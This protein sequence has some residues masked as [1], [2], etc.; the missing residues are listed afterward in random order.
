MQQPE[1]DIY[2]LEVERLTKKPEK[3][4][5]AWLNKSPLFKYSGYTENMAFGSCGCPTMIRMY[6]SPAVINGEI[7]H[8][9][10]NAIRADI[11][12]PNYTNNITPA[13]LPRFAYWQRI[14]DRLTAGE[15]VQL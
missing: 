5:S 13:H 7:N 8:E 4:E 10:T 11:G 9:L 14:I 6:T 3:I 12:I 1:K 2:D 15:E